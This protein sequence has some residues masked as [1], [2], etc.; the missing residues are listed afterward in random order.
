VQTRLGRVADVEIAALPAALTLRREHLAGAKTRHLGR[1]VGMRQFGVNHITLEPG[2][3]SALR[4]WHEKEDEFVYVLEGEVTLVD[5]NG[6]H[7]L[8]AGDVAGFP[9]GVPNAHHLTNRSREPVRLL[10]VGTRFVGS[11]TVHYMDDPALGVAT[12]VRGPDGERQPG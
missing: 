10:V 12:V 8:C 6:S 4:H 11:E 1:A 7:V 5:E 3:I 9:A 2:A